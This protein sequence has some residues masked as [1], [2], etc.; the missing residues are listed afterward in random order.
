MDYSELCIYYEKLDATSSRLEKTDVLAEL[1][2]KSK[3]DDLKN[4]VS[5]TTEVTK[6]RL[7][8]NV[9]WWQILQAKTWR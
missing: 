3:N 7:L 1:L 6:M 4:V 8:K 5:L 2:K 9:W